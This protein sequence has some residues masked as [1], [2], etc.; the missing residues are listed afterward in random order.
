MWITAGICSSNKIMCSPLRGEEGNL[1]GYGQSERSGMQSTRLENP[2][3]CC[4]AQAVGEFWVI[5][6]YIVYCFHSYWLGPLKKMFLLLLYLQSSLEH[7]VYSRLSTLQEGLIPKKRAGTDDDLHR[8]NELIQ[9]RLLPQAGKMVCEHN[10]NQEG[11]F[12]RT[13]LKMG[14]CLAEFA[15]LSLSCLLRRL[16]VS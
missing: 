13:D 6:F 2:S 4:T 12:A 11:R 16:Y 14:V 8:I 9:V 5:S 15:C 10:L 3:V 1:T 7:D